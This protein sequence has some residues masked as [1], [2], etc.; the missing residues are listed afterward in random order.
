MKGQVGN[1]IVWCSIVLGQP[2][3]I[4]MYMHDYYWIHVAP[5]ANATLL[6]TSVWGEEATWE[7]LGFIKN[8]HRLIYYPNSFPHTSKSIYLHHVKDIWLVCVSCQIVILCKSAA[9]IIDH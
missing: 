8:L 5:S 1:I 2:V 3:A 7:N 6:G 4:L 9:S